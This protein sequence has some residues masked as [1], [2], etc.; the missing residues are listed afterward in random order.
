MFPSDY[1]ARQSRTTVLTLP[2]SRFRITLRWREAPH[3]LGERLAEPAVESQSG[4]NG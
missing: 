4:R 1:S 3:L 2:L